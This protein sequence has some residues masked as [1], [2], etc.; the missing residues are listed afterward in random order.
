MRLQ[1]LVRLVVATVCA[2]GLAGGVAF[3]QAGAVEKGAEKTGQAVEKGATKTGHALGKAAGATAHGASKA[4][5]KT[6]DATEKAVAKTGTPMDINSA[7]KADLMTL[8]GIGDALSQ[9]IIDNRPYHAKNELVTKKVVP[10][11]TYAK[12]KDGIIAS[13]KK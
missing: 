13:Q 3:A 9:K 5:T 11:S 2:C 8:P 12:I 10:E 1:R 6:A 7:S 4:A